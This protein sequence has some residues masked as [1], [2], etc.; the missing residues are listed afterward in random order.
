[1]VSLGQAI[2]ATRARAE[3]ERLQTEAVE[4][5]ARLKE[6]N[7]L[8][9]NARANADQQLW[10][11]ALDQYSH[12]IQ[13]QPEHY[14]AWAGRG[15]LYVRLAA[16]QLAAHDFAKAIEL[17]APANNPGW[18]GVPQLFAVVGDQTALRQIVAA[19]RSQVDNGNDAG[20]ILMAIRGICQQ[21][22]DRADALKLLARV[23]ALEQSTDR[24]RPGPRRFPPTGPE[25]PDDLAR[26]R[27]PG[28]IGSMALADRMD[29]ADPA[30]GHPR[31]RVL[32]HLTWPT[33]CCSMYVVW[34]L[35]GPAS[36][37]RSLNGCSRPKRL[38][39]PWPPAAVGSAGRGLCRTG[40][41][42]AGRHTCR[43]P[44]E[45]SNAGSRRFRTDDPECPGLT[46]WKG[47][48][49]CPRPTR[50]CTLRPTP[51][52]P[53]SVGT[54]ARSTNLRLA[55][56]VGCAACPQPSL[57]IGWDGGC[58]VEPTARLWARQFT[59]CPFPSASCHCAIAHEKF[60]PI[61]CHP[62]GRLFA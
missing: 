52:M 26:R 55:A 22:L 14:L 6:A 54:T 2:L 33:I 20:R 21:P 25:P 8:L 4:S 42:G 9:D 50:S 19:L 15:G 44:S 36:A 32:C 1:M 37:H 46:D 41:A 35:I 10:S 7:I 57:G 23:D 31:D 58:G 30:R 12:A 3:A 49:C 43:R 40:A 18:W 29:L 5:V 62:S 38:S 28:R 47:P 51:W 61:L 11:P 24:G 17:G 27:P 34:P 60:W 56:M 53:C 13:L 39:P 48:R 45:N 16:W 59:T